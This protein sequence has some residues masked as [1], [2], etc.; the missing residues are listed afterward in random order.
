MQSTSSYSKASV[1]ARGVELMHKTAN[2]VYEVYSGWTIGHRLWERTQ[3]IMCSIHFQAIAISFLSFTESNHQPH[4]ANKSSSS[5]DG[6][7]L[8]NFKTMPDVRCSKISTLVVNIN[9]FDSLLLHTYHLTPWPHC[10]KNLTSAQWTQLPAIL[11]IIDTIAS[12]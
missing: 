9:V 11:C 12:L 1:K 4:Y 8:W 2:W 7:Y 10:L 3:I 6:F 5:L